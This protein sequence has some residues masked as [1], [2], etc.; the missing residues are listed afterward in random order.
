MSRHSM[1]VTAVL[2]VQAKIC[3]IVFRHSVQAVTSHV[4]SVAQANV[5]WNAGEQ[6]VI[7]YG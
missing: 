5:V 6:T 2:R 7:T 4:L 3:V 1:Q